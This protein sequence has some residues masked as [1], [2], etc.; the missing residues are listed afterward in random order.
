MW[1]N[2]T[3]E[4]SGTKDFCS[5]TVTV[6]TCVFPWCLCPL[7]RLHHVYVTTRFA[8]MC[9]CVFVSFA[10]TSRQGPLSPRDGLPR[11]LS[12]LGTAA[13]FGF[14]YLAKR[15]RLHHL[16]T[17]SISIAS[18][19]NT[20]SVFCGVAGV[21][22]LQHINRRSVRFTSSPCLAKR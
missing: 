8:S 1:V 7:L 3:V 5:V 9:F 10:R 20:C 12:L 17:A 21:P 15:V 13:A 2:R 16:Q 14:P 4:S 6:T 22:A 11:A 19:P 18:P